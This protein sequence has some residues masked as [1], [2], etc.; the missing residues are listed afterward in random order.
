[1]RLIF[2]Y[3]ICSFLLS[4][5]GQ[6]NEAVDNKADN[7][8]E[9]IDTVKE[10]P[11]FFP[12]GN[13]IKGQILEIR[14]NGINPKKITLNGN[15][16]DSS[17]LKVE[18]F[19][20]EFGEYYTPFIDSIQLSKLFIE[21][22]FFDQTLDAITLTYD[23]IGVLPD[24]IPWKHWDIYIDPETNL[25]KRIY[26]VKKIDSNKTR[27]LTWLPG[28]NCRAITIEDN[29]NGNVYKS[30]TENEVTIKWNY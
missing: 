28:I 15:K 5:C 9:E 29:L 11:S 27:Q 8:I 10:R 1:M 26:L 13:F 17:W 4:S 20:K 14:N 18:Q 30:K 25:V 16:I 19:E 6:Q 24:S 21:Q 22:K 12:V 3:V 2:F 23:P 7:Q